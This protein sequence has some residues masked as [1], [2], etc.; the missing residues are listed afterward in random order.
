LEKKK[1]KIPFFVSLCLYRK[2]NLSFQ[3]LVR[4]FFSSP[5]FSPDMNRQIYPYP[6]THTL[7]YTPQLV[8][9]NSKPVHIARLQDGHCISGRKVGESSKCGADSLAFILSSRTAE[10]CASFKSESE[11]NANQ[12]MPYISVDLV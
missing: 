9:Q 1:Q 6:Q 4:H 10:I 8:Y 5:R 7:N 11:Q 12:H 3:T 2:Y